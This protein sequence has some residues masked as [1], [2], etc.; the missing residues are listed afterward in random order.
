MIGPSL[1]SLQPKI[2]N[3]YWISICLSQKLQAQQA[4]KSTKYIIKVNHDT[5]YKDGFG[6]KMKNAKIF[7]RLLN[8]VQL[9]LV[10]QQSEETG[11]ASCRLL[12]NCSDSE[13][14]MKSTKAQ[15]AVWTKCFPSNRTSS[16]ISWNSCLE[17]SFNICPRLFAWKENMIFEETV[18]S[19][20]WIGNI[21]HNIALCLRQELEL[22]TQ[23]Y[24]TVQTARCAVQRRH[25]KCQMFCIQT[26]FIKYK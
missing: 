25:G 20:L 24:H 18:N 10:L 26:T 22:Q 16:D 13:T 6:K 3:Y 23:G 19:K 12:K 11:R 7:W 21:L 14:T 17:I 4:F 1:A 9:V 2:K 8:D 5:F 15:C